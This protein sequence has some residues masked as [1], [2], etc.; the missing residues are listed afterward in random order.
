MLLDVKLADS[1]GLSSA[2]AKGS[3]PVAA[4]AANT[5]SMVT[6]AVSGGGKYGEGKCACELSYMSCGCLARRAQNSGGVAPH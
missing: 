3:I 4:A 5:A 1:E 2:E 6:K